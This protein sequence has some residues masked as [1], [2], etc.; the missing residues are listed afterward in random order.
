MDYILYEQKGQYAQSDS[1]AI[2]IELFVHIDTQVFAHCYGLSR[3]SFVRLDDIEIFDLH[4][5]LG[6]H[7]FGGCHRADTHHLGTNACQ[8]ACYSIQ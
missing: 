2:G 7:L 4:T 8:S 5:G 3:K 1:A 6:Q